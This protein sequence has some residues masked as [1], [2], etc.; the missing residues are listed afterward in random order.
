VLVQVSHRLE[1]AQVVERDDLEI[2]GILVHDDL[3]DLAA[4]TTE[5]I[6]TNTCCHG[7]SLLTQSERVADKV[8]PSAR[9]YPVRVGAVQARRLSYSERRVLGLNTGR[10][11]LISIEQR[12]GE[13]LWIVPPGLLG[14]GQI[15]PHNVISV[16]DRGDVR[17]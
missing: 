15:G 11:T 9:D 10:R 14:I 13:L 17:L 8:A 7:C 3:H 1:V 12:L 2:V 5:A 16:G 6:D 4:N